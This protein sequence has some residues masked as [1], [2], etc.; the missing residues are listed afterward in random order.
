[1]K[2]GFAWLPLGRNLSPRFCR[3]ELGG[4]RSIVTESRNDD[5]PEWSF[6]QHE[7]CDDMPPMITETKPFTAEE[8]QRLLDQIEADAPTFRPKR[9]TGGAGITGGK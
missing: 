4:G 7:S 8:W 1:M 6:S 2:K 5:M 9:S 3:F